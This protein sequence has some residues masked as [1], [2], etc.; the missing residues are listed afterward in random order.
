M[1]EVTQLKKRKEWVVLNEAARDAF[2]KLKKAVMSAP[3]LAYPD[4]QQRIFARN[5]CLKAGT[6]DCAVPE[7]IQWEVPSSCL[8]EQGFTWSGGQLP[9]YKTQ[10]FGH[11]MVY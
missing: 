8:W 4:S 7:T 2:H 6:K 9:Q 11:E 10:V 3:V 1:Q 5:Q